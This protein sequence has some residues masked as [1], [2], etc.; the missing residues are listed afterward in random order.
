[1]SPSTTA[2]NSEVGESSSYEH[3]EQVLIRVASRNSMHSHPLNDEA[4]LSGPPATHSTCESSNVALSVNA[5]PK[6]MD[7]G[8]ASHPVDVSQSGPGC[9]T[10]DGAAMPTSIPASSAALS[11]P[12]QISLS[13]PLGA[14]ALKSLT[15]E[16][17]SITS[18]TKDGTTTVETNPIGPPL[19]I[20]TNI[21]E[22]FSYSDAAVAAAAVATAAAASSSSTPQS[23]SSTGPERSTKSKGGSLR[24]GKWTSEEET[25]VARV[26]HDFNSGFLNAPA[27]TTLRSYLSDKL[28]CDPMRITKKFTGD[29]CIGKRVFHPAV[30][31]AANG[32]SIDKAQVLFY[33]Q[34]V[35]F[36]Y[37]ASIVFEQSPHR[38]FEIFCHRIGGTGS[39]GE[40]MAPS[41]R[42]A[43]ARIG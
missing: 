13:T 2:S 23:T 6:A 3:M 15:I 16:P 10:S 1:M 27:G 5:T 42:N 29:S 25:Y 8:E 41:P 37:L 33:H 34:F 32:A 7:P 28:Q 12:S 19:V 22:I 21:P 4:H 30:R 31:S 24:R 9:A 35:S 20:M 17:N 18:G 14:T 39:P 11:P 43:T 36:S 40:A 26:I 38:S